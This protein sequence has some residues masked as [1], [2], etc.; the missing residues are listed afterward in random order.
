MYKLLQTRGVARLQKVIYAL[1]GHDIYF[2][3]AENQ[4]KLIYLQLWQ[5]D[6]NTSFRE[7]KHRCF[8][9]IC[10]FAMY[11]IFPVFLVYH[12]TY[13]KVYR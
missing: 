1:I 8:L 3:T 4:N 7:N 5:V 12:L 13:L 11:K 2:F 10:S 9:K 6:Q